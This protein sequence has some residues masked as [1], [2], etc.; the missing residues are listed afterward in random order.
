M[1]APDNYAGVGTSDIIVHSDANSNGDDNR[2]VIYGKTQTAYWIN[3]LFA[4]FIY[5][6]RCCSHIKVPTVI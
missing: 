6:C 4:K 2:S 5:F 1:T 3:L